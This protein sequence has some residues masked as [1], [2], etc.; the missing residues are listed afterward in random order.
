M[1]AAAGLRRVTPHRRLTARVAC[2]VF[3]LGIAHEAPATD[4][5]AARPY[6]LYRG[7]PQGWA[8]TD[9]VDWAR[10][11]TIAEAPL[12]HAAQAL[13]Q[14]QIPGGVSCNLIVDED[15][16]VFAAGQGQVT[17][18]SR[19]GAREYSHRTDSPG[20]RAATLLADG[21]RA[22]L[23]RDGQV[24][25]WSR[26]GKA[27][28]SLKLAALPAG[29][30][31]SLLPLPDGGALVS[32]G[33]W[34]F[35]LEASGAIR[36][37][38]LLKQG[39]DHTLIAHDSSVVI[40]DRGDV[41]TWDGESAPVHRGSFGGRVA[42]ITARGPSSLVG[43]LSDR[44]L[45]ELSLTT[46]GRKQL[47]GTEKL[48]LLPVLAV[49]GSESFGLMTADGSAFLQGSGALPA[50]GTSRAGKADPVAEAHLLASADGTLISL[51]SNT[52]L[53]LQKS[54]EV[55]EIPEVRCAR[56]VSLVPAGP[57]RVVAACSS[58][59][60]WLIGPTADARTDASPPGLKR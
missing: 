60:L 55:Q 10:S 35:E 26:N 37:R 43:L 51:S 41:M 14:A 19:D 53:R 36:G 39:I 28:F 30:H 31:G 1:I 6:T 12:P 54:G 17:Q 45:S 42:R 48:G 21:A 18:L 13:W 29:A 24:S 38:A 15:G 3:L 47:A 57:S 8:T 59:Q 52:A 7:P 2:G 22:V 25:A 56:P 11:Y 9:G 40:D 27:R 46:G 50:N 34:L 4:V 32:T 16:R 44:G 49:S 23:T 58:G 20:A 33:A 5:V